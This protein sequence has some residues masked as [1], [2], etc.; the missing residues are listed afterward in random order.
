MHIEKANAEKSNTVGDSGSVEKKDDE[1]DPNRVVDV[2]YGWY[3]NGG[4]TDWNSSPVL[5][6]T[7]ADGRTL[8]MGG[9]Y[10]TENEVLD[11]NL[12]CSVPFDILGI[13]AQH[14]RHIVRL[15]QYREGWAHWMRQKD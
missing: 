7:L 8:N 12:F 4:G 5:V 13:A 2:A 6:K 11:E 9:I 1:D 10:T 14:R 3:E 15:M